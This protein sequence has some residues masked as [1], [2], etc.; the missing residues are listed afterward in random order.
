MREFTSLGY[1]SQFT[2]WDLLHH[3]EQTNG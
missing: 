3:L 1:I 2:A